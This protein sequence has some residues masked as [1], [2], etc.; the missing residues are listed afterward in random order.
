MSL[1]KG[2]PLWISQRAQPS[3]IALRPGLRLLVSAA[4]HLYSGA[5]EWDSLGARKRKAVRGREEREGLEETQD[6][7]MKIREEECDVPQQIR[8]E[9]KKTRRTGG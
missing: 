5:Q 4:A 9:K 7:G 6:K 1:L 3:S 8:M 2:H